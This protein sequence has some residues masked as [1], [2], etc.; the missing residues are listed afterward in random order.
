MGI[1]WTF[2]SSQVPP[3]PQYFPDDLLNN[4]CPQP[5]P[6]QQPDRGP[7]PDPNIIRAQEEYESDDDDDDDT[8]S[9]DEDY[10]DESEDD[11]W[12][13]RY[14]HITAEDVLRAFNFIEHY[15]NFEW[16]HGLS[17]DTIT[18]HL[19]TRMNKTEDVDEDCEAEICVICQDCLFEG[20]DEIA[21]LDCRH[22]YHVGCI[23]NWLMQKNS[24]PLCNAKG[25]CVT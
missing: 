23:K 4:P 1:V 21:T 5:D 9:E 8:S 20:E 14:E 3:A 12:I 17:E 11:S 18:K 10:L 7:Q 25:V 2:C 24:C 13:S 15:S 19:K 16:I 6:E 22:E